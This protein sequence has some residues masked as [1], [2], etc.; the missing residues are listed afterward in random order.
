MQPGE[1]ATSA[2]NQVTWHATIGLTRT[3]SAKNKEWN[4]QAS[5]T[6]RS[7]T[8]MHCNICKKD[9][10]NEADCSFRKKDSKR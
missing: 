2:T 3:H 10:H 9:N 8:G 7:N 1:G 4:F 5:N 6:E